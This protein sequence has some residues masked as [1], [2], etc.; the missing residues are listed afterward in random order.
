MTPGVSEPVLS[1][2]DLNVS[3]SGLT[4]RFSVV[5]GVSFD[6]VPGEITGLVGETG[7]GKTMTGSALMGMV[8]A[9]AG[10]VSAGLLQLEG[11]DVKALT[12][13]DWRRIRGS[14]IS[15]IFQEPLSA[16]DPVLTIGSQLSEVIR[17]HQR[18]GKQDALASANGLLEAV[19][20]KDSRQILRSY[21]H[22]LSGGMRQRVMIAMAMSCKPRVLIADEPTT[23][24]DVTTQQQILQQ[25]GELARDSGTAVLLITHDLG[26]VAQVCDQALVMHRGRIV[27]RGPASKVFDAPQHPYTASL[28][29]ALPGPAGRSPAPSSPSTTPPLLAVRD[30]RMSYPA[31]RTVGRRQQQA[32]VVRGVSFDLRAGEIYGLV[33][34]SG[35]GKT[36][37]ARSIIRLSN[38]TSGSAT[39]REFN[40]AQMKGSKL[41]YARR[42]IQ[43]LFQDPHA[44][45]SPRRT[46]Q[47]ML[48]EPLQLYRIGTGREYSHRIEQALQT[49][50]LG[51][52]VLPRYPHELSGGQRQRLSL[53][54]ALLAEP[55]LI[56][57]DE[58]MSS[59][60]VSV[61]ARI[62]ELIDKVRRELEIAFLLIS[63]D[64]AVVQHLADQVGV[65]YLGELLESGPVETV[66]R[67][68]AHPYTQALLAAMPSTHKHGTLPVS[69]QGEAPS[70][71]T[72]PA[73]CVF[74]TRCP[75]FM[76]QCKEVHPADIVISDPAAESGNPNR[77][78][79]ARCHLWNS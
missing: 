65:M 45:L 64:L 5:D 15:M 41:R 79:L 43:Y 46:I 53:A 68:P 66:F 2:R 34:E 56:I 6:L 49:V 3:F 57:A 60:D 25:I 54:R 63:H 4:G 14:Q 62:I 20:L 24:L 21:P 32:E 8:P 27:E 58:P 36:S 39:F 38:P 73:G 19:G 70:A 35:C 71:L 75:Q 7:S 42:K 22:Q 59:L 16:L 67:R 17:R 74:H 51:P 47:Q 13:A 50:D 55:A 26:V 77:Q 12:E 52:D 23:A 69:L 28:L 9:P 61:Q 40:L 78:H 30:I 48:T 31:R 29:A 10:Q 33:G 18:C 37:L 44:S 72:P 1:V 11:Q 76:N